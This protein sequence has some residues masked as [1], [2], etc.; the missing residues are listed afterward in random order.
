MPKFIPGEPT[1]V[2]QN[3]TGAEGIRAANYLYNVA[4]QDG[5]VIG[6]LSRNNGLARF[7]DVANSS[8]Q[9]DARKFH[10][11]GSPQQEIGLFILNTKTGLKSIEELKGHEITASSTAHSAPTSIYARMLNAMYGTKI[12]VVEGYAGSQECLLAVERNEVDGHVS[13]GSSG[14]FR[15]RI[16][17]WLKSGATRVILQQ[18][19]VR[20]AAFPDIPT[21]IEIVSKP[22]DKQMFEIA[23]AEQV[24]GRPFVMPPGV[25]ADRVKVLRDAFDKAVKDPALL[26]DAK[27]QNMEIDPV[28]GAEINALLDR[29]YAAPPDLVTR[30]RE[31]AKG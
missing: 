5:S 14:A 27:T 11:L 8:I 20:D 4:P 23:F 13:G 21:A 9:F 6:G 15:A 25:P 10:W 19:M 22:E 2:V 18:G 3:M 31:L 16:A 30:L 12:K 28:S 26:E 1:I 7:Y 29:V 17:P 24:M